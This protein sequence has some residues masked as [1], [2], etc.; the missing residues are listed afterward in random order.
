MQIADD[1]EVGDEINNTVTFTYNST[2]GQANSSL[3][4]GS[5]E[6]DDATPPSAPSG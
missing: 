1:V 2:T 4:I 5:S 3:T 6:D